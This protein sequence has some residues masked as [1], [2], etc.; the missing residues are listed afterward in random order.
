[1]SRVC[2][3]NDVAGSNDVFGFHRARALTRANSSRLCALPS[4]VQNQISPE[5]A[6]PHVCPSVWF[7]NVFY[8]IGMSWALNLPWFRI[9]QIC[10]LEQWSSKMVR[11]PDG[12]TDRNSFD[13]SKRAMHL[14]RGAM[15]ISKIQGNGV[16]YLVESTKICSSFKTI[17][18]ANIYINLNS[19]K[20]NCSA[21]QSYY[22]FRR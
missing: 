21:A 1:M 17:I 22:R 15:C 9:S 11:F 10:Q 8:I 6:T 19:I 4:F 12:R 13:S 3:L 2:G 18:R 14:A 7:L 5:V 20:S 16:V